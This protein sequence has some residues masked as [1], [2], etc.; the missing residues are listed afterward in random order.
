MLSR[1]SLNL[2]SNQKTGSITLE[3]RQIINLEKTNLIFPKISNSNL[4]KKSHTLETDE[5]NKKKLSNFGH[6]SFMDFKGNEL[7]KSIKECKPENK[8][9][10]Y[11]I[12]ETLDKDHETF[13]RNKSFVF[14]SSTKN[15]TSEKKGQIDSLTLW[16]ESKIINF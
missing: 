14:S 7:D 10:E 12:F 4:E 2:I 3:N 9:K 6:H 15:S 1:N 16:K 5:Y 13:K 11:Q 8:K